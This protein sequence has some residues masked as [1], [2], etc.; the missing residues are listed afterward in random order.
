MSTKKSVFKICVFFKA[1]VV[2]LYYFSSFWL[3][4]HYSD[5]K[6]NKNKI[7]INIRFKNLFILIIIVFNIIIYNIW[8]IIIKVFGYIFF[9]NF[10]IV[11]SNKIIYLNLIFII[12]K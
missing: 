10:L 6:S 11:F 2:Y 4:T 12:K 1:S 3:T 8:F 9:L 5:K 7:G